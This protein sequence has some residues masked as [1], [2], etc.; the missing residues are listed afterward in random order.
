MALGDNAK[1]S[2]SKGVPGKTGS[3]DGNQNSD[4]LKAAIDAGWAFIEFD[5]TGIVTNVNDNFLKALGYSK[6]GVVG[7]HHKM[8]CDAEY[9]KGAGYKKFWKDL[10]E[11]E[12]KAGDFERFTKSGKAVWIK[13]SYT[14][15][16]NAAGKVEK[17]I[18]IATVITDQKKMEDDAAALKSAVDVGWAQI[19]F[20]PVGNIIDV[21]ENF[22][23]TLGYTKEELIGQHH[24]MFCETN[25]TNSADYKIFWKDLGDGKV[26]NGDFERFTKDGTSV[27]IKA[28]YAPVLDKEGKVERVIK[29]ATVITEAKTAELINEQ[30]RAAFVEATKFIRALAVGDFEEVMNTKELAMDENTSAV[31]EDLYGL[32]D[33]VKGIIDEV[34]LVVVEAGDKGNLN[35]RLNIDSAEGQWKSL[36]DSINLLMQSIAEPMLEFNGII[37]GMAGGDL[38]NKFEMVSAGD[39]KEM[40]DSLNDCIT[41]LNS[42]LGNISDSSNVVADTAVSMESQS[43]AMGATTTEVA[44]AITQMARG[45]QEQAQKTDESSRMIEQVMKSSSE[46][47]SKAADINSAANQ[48]QASCNEGLKIMEQ[49]LGNMTD[50]EGSAGSTAESISVLTER[51]EEI[52][53]TLNVI[54]DIAAQTN[55]LALNAAI[56]AAR[57][58]E[59]GRGFAVVAEEIRKLAENSKNA[60][61]SIETIISNVQKDTAQASKAIE[62][63]TGAVKSGNSASSSAQTIFEEINT[64][65]GQTLAFANEIQTATSEQGEVII[66]VVKN[67]EQIVVVAEETAAGTEEVASSASE[68]NEAM[69]D[70]KGAANNMAAVAAEL[71][72]GV[73][74]FK[75]DNGS[76]DK[77]VKVARKARR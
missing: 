63:M 67:I 48:G 37:S 43:E 5:P 31:I 58:G 44:S 27:W 55:L 69:G 12:I 1:K 49:L 45:A 16:K 38:T 40:G 73:N 30:N 59:A 61:V 29:I 57:A 14:P 8:F 28:S 56:E 42:L 25:Y 41:N 18:K 47:A 22:Y 26:N 3:S 75:L 77:P 62:T 24:R 35:A 17:V 72:A 50:I 70:V 71:Q 6:Q 64:Q 20:D 19:E 10:G 2:N 76:S 51:A 52:G 60:A 36:V 54:T 23:K 15:V 33:S 7:K 39:I 53:R 9:I 46:M 21:N 66:D 13:A 32:R 65:T 11:G 4:S 74:Q 34:N 68:L